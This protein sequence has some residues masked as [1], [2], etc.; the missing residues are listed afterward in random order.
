MPEIDGDHLKEDYYA[1]TWG[2][3]LF[4]VIDPFW[5]TMKKPYTGTMGG[6]KNDEVVGNR[7]DWTLGDQQYLWL[8][9]TLESSTAKFKFVFAHH[10]T[11]GTDDYIRGGARGAK[12]C[13]WGGYD[14]TTNTYEFA[15]PPSGMG[16][17]D[18]PA[19]RAQQ[20]DG[21]LPRPRSRLRQGDARR[22]RLPGGPASRRAPPTARALPTIRA[23]TPAPTAVWSTTRVTCASR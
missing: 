22:R 20:R 14:P 2:D 3:A 7:W 21:L 12:Y 10:A 16:H 19:L 13:E 5:Y 11:G 6:E 23:T 15:D 8:K 9:H 18:P 4:V 1:F 17:A